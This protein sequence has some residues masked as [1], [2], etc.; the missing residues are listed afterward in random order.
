MLNKIYTAM[1]AMK[2]FSNAALR[3]FSKCFL[4]ISKIFQNTFGETS[5]RVDGS[6][7]FRKCIQR[8]FAREI[9]QFY[10]QVAYTSPKRMQTVVKEL[11][12]FSTSFD[13]TSVQFESLLKANTKMKS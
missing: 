10:V 6:E 7:L 9:G 4:E 5:A 12:I 8:K 2:T 3:H 13:M 1:I 11:N